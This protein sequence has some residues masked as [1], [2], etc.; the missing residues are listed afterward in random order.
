MSIQYSS[1][2]WPVCAEQYSSGSLQM[3]SVLWM[4]YV[5]VEFYSWFTYCFSL[6]VGVGDASAELVVR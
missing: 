1:S 6:S 3:E 4:R 2:Q 5:V